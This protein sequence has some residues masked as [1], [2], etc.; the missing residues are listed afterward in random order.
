MSSEHEHKPRI[1]ITLGDFNGVGPELIIKT[2]AD[3]RMLQVCTPVIYG[4]S[5]VISFHRK[6]INNQEFNYNTVRN[7]K[8]V[9]HRK[10]NLINCWE[11]EVK[12]DIGKPSAIAGQ[13]AFRSLDAAVNDLHA[14]LIDGLVTAPIDKHTIQSD[15]FA[16]PGH[17]EFLASKFNTKKY[18]MMLVGDHL[19]VVVLT[20]HI[21]VSAVA[22]SISSEKIVD[23]LLL[24]SESLKRDFGIRKP[25]I[26]VLGLNPHG[27]DGGLIGKE[28]ETIILPAIKQANEKNIFVYGPYASDGFFATG[29]Y[30][31][32]DAV[33]AMYHD[34][35]LIPFK[36]IAFNNGV[37]Y[38]A[39]LSIVRCSPDH[40]TAY[41]IA[42]KGIASEDSFREAVYM[43]C[44]ILEK[45]KMHD[46]VNE[47][48]LAFTKMSGER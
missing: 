33:L 21:P 15:L 29:N 14:G 22:S 1:G 7:I 25:K 34:Q 48:P 28:E 45:R 10:V 26:A 13:Y 6:A 5:K 31:K 35:G 24:I 20:G 47:K 42:G 16:F 9:I 44:N 32:F 38:T 36:T 23:T 2:F 30:R 37:N 8:E 17:T 27:G 12:I 43:T 39:G 3:T 19:R 11:E 4:S 41:D 46:D 18:A 40:G